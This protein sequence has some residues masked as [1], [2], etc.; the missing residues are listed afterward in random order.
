MSSYHK[1]PKFNVSLS[2]YT[3][4]HFSCTFTHMYMLE[5]VVQWDPCTHIHTQTLLCNE[6]AMHVHKYSSRRTIRSSSVS[7]SRW[8]I[9]CGSGTH[10]CSSSSSYYSLLLDDPLCQL[11]LSHSG[12]STGKLLPGGIVV[13]FLPVGYHIVSTLSPTLTRV[14]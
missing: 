1:D 3:I 8:V 4:L 12:Q 2:V 9:L 11:V 6:Y 10:H 13:V 5:W 14:E 7:H